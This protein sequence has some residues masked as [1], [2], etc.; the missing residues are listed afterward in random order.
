MNDLIVFFHL[1]IIIIS[2]NYHNIIYLFIYLC[3]INITYII[4]Y[5]KVDNDEEGE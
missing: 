5:K 1:T 2:K 3:D 4:I